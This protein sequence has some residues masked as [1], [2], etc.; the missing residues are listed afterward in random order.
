MIHYLGLLL[1]KIKTLH[2]FLSVNSSLTT[3]T[4]VQH[5]VILENYGRALHEFLSVN[6]SLTTLTLVQHQV[7]LENY[8]RVIVLYFKVFFFLINSSFPI[9]ML[10]LFIFSKILLILTATT[11]FGDVTVSWGIFMKEVLMIINH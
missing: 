2:E 1:T 7:I 8:G 3:L 4:L 6:S 9:F 11:Q 5:Q 10:K